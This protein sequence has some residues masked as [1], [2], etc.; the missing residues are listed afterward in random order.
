MCW[1]ETAGV[2]SKIASLS[3]NHELCHPLLTGLKACDPNTKLASSGT[4]LPK[5]E[6]RALVPF[7]STWFAA[8]HTLSFSSLLFFAFCISLHLLLLPITSTPT[9]RQ[10]TCTPLRS[11]CYTGQ[12]KLVLQPLPQRGNQS[13]LGR[14]NVLHF[15]PIERRHSRRVRKRMVVK[16]SRTHC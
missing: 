10:A 16:L 5:K 2:A 6:H 1:L 14:G 12:R 7:V 8:S 13:L 15:P 11:G 4:F 9:C 3:T